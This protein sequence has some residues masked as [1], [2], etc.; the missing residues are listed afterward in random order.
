[1]SL[2]I[3][4]ITPGVYYTAEAYVNSKLIASKEI[5]KSTTPKSSTSI[6]DNKVTF[7]ITGLNYKQK[8]GVFIRENYEDSP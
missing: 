8:V 6:N 1:L 4:N 5:Y 3:S 7:Y 2:S